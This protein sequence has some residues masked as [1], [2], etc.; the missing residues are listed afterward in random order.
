MTAPDKN[1]HVSPT[2]RMLALLDL[3][4]VEEQERV[5]AHLED[6]KPCKERMGEARAALRDIAIQEHVPASVLARWDRLHAQMGPRERAMIERHLRG[7]GTCSEALSAGLALRSVQI[8]PQKAALRRSL[9]WGLGFAFAVV[10]FLVLWPRWR[11]ERHSE[12]A[13][14]AD[15]TAT[16]VEPATPPTVPVAPDREQ[17][18]DEMAV[19]LALA[20][21]GQS[22]S[23]LLAPQQRD[24]GPAAS[25]SAAG[26][27]RTLRLRVPAL[28][29]LDATHRLRVRLVGPGDRTFATHTT[30]PGEL[31]ER[32]VLVVDSKQAWRSGDYRVEIEDLTPPEPGFEP[33][34]ISLPFRID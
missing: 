19:Q 8:Q 2:E 32:P 17:V 34:V 6:C 23:L 27:I 21:V 18:T 22:P 33:E 16:A 1:P 3:L 29:L 14:R 9:G 26:R 7:C 20:P 12:V 13:T 10:L 28:P 4:D 25:L 15:S 11:A 24:S 30:L 31:T 5:D